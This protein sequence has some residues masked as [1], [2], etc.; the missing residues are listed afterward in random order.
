[1][2]D[3]KLAHVPVA[4]SDDTGA[5]WD[6][7]IRSESFEEADRR[8]NRLLLGGEH[9]EAFLRADDESRSRIPRISMLC[10]GGSASL[11]P[12]APGRPQ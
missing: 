1:M 4:R 6:R 2:L 3:S 12:L 11:N 9:G 10:T 8:S 7:Q 5:V